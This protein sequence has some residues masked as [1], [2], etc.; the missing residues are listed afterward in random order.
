M[1]LGVRGPAPDRVSFFARQG[2]F[3]RIMHDT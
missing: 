3:I 1:D 2:G